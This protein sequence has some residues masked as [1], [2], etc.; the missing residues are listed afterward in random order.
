LD[1]VNC[2]TFAKSGATVVNPFTM[3]MGEIPFTRANYLM[4]A[5]KTL[6]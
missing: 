2:Q 6:F 1:E 3:E 4:M 5:R